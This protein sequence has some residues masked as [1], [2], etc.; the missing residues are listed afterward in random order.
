[1]TFDAFEVIRLV[2]KLPLKICSL[3]TW[4]EYVQKKL[5]KCFWGGSPE[6]FG[7]H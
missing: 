3:A 4:G 1:M 6:K 7:G 5:K 2:E